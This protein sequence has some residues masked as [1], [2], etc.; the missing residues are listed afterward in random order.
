[1]AIFNSYVS[2]PDHNQNAETECPSTK[3]RILPTS[4]ADN[5]SIKERNATTETLRDVQ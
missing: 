5:R 4:P 1:M 3:K 2:L